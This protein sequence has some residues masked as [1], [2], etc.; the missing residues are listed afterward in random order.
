MSANPQ[1]TCR[2]PEAHEWKA[3][4]HADGCHWYSTTYAC[5]ACGATLIETC[6]RS[7]TED[8]GSA[9]WMED[10]GDS[11]CDRCAELLAGAE[12]QSQSHI[13]LRSA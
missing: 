10:L 11:F 12:P 9:V 5:L 7:M 6:E 13:D 3:I 2:S 8:P 4:I 1:T